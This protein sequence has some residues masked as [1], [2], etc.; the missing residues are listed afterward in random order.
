MITIEQLLRNYRKPLI[1]A[2]PKSLLRLPQ[3]VSKLSD[4]APGTHFLPVIDDE[5]I[6]NVAN[7]SRV[8]FMSGKIFYDL[9]RERTKKQLANVAL[10]R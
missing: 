7:V 4:M 2:G 8:C 3:A 10:I 9:S 6:E 1:I 5:S